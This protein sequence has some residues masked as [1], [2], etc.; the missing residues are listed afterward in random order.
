MNSS[1]QETAQGSY[2]NEANHSFLFFHPNTSV[3]TVTQ[4]GTE[5]PGSLTPDPKLIS[6]QPA[7]VSTSCVHLPISKC[8]RRAWL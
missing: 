3:M 2:E 6:V 7:A 4:F 1:A 5:N 8:R